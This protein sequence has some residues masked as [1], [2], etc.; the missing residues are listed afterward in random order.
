M[1]HINNHM[2]WCLKDENKL[3]KIKPDYKLAKDHMKKSEYNK[4][5][6]DILR[7]AGKY[8]WALNVGFYAIYHCFLAMEE[9]PQFRQILASLL[10]TLLCIII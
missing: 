3:K 2:K 7:N 10:F 6:M 4:E 5:V 8:D 9:D 1:A